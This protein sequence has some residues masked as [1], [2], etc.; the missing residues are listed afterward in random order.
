MPHDP[1]T[2]ARLTH[3]IAKLEDNARAL[4]KH[5][6]AFSIKLPSRKFV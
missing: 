1:E 4:Q 3:H 5:A 2:I 6:V